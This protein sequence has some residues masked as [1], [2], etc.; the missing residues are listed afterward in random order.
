MSFEILVKKYCDFLKVKYG[1]EEKSEKLVYVKGVIE[2][3]F[4]QGKGELDIVFFINKQDEIFKPFVSRSFYLDEIVRRV[5]K[6]PISYPQTS[7]GY[8]ISDEDIEIHL[9][10]C[11]KL[12]KK[13]C[14]LQLEGDLSLFEE[15]HLERRG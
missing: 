14:Y 1:F 10:F 3:E 11:A 13:Y 7:S 15:I 4:Y 12:L 8:L 6:N 2:I 9:K 5:N